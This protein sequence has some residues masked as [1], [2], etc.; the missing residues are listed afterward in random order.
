MTTHPTATASSASKM[1]SLPRSPYSQP[2]TLR[3]A[4]QSLSP[5]RT[6][7]SSQ[8]YSI[9]FTWKT[10]PL[11]GMKPTWKKCSRNTERLHQ[12]SVSRTKL[13][14]SASCAL[15][16]TSLMGKPNS[17]LHQRPWKILMER[18][19]MKP[20][21]FMSRLLSLRVRERSKSK[22]KCSDTRTLRRDATSTLR[23]SHPLQLNSNWEN[24]SELMEISKVS[25]CSKRKMKQCMPSFVSN[26]LK[27]HQRPRLN[28]TKSHSMESNFSLTIMKSRKS[29]RH[30]RKRFMIRL[31][32]K[33]IRR[34]I[35]MLPIC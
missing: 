18:N 16:S 14:L 28:F 35:P 12:L 26:H 31:T 33:T 29:E 19:L 15:M 22:R 30:N 21:P 3:P 5:P 4:K 32:S 8:R 1:P 27:R 10:S 17:P 2:R 20:T 23:I 25:N 11:N 6:R 9:T 24:F 13:E 7:P 34:Q